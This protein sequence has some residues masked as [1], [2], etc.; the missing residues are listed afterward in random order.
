MGNSH[1]P[2]LVDRFGAAGLPLQLARAPI[3]RALGAEVV[4]QMDIRRARAWDPHSE[5]YVA[6]P[7]ASENVVHVQGVDRAAHQLVMMVREP[8]RWF[9]EPVPFHLMRSA[10]RSASWRGYVA[11]IARVPADEI[12]GSPAQAWVRRVTETRKRHFLVGRDERQLFMCR[13]PRACTTVQQAHDALRVPEAAP[14]RSAL[15]RPIRQGEWFFVRAGAVAI[16]TIERDLAALRA[17]VRRKIS[18]GQIIER[19]GKPHVADELV[20]GRDEA[21]NRLVFVRGAVRHLDHETIRLHEW[22]RVYRNREVDEGR[23]PFGGGW[24]D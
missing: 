14:A 9:F 12:V 13:L 10:R 8:R 22:H 3:A 17:W 2:H 24:I 1:L 5:Y 21:G 19:G 15:E 16:A 11:Q 6:W 7:G 23:S 18:I 20:V 4:F